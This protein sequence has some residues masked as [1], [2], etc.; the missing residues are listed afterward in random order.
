MEQECCPLDHTVWWNTNVVDP[1]C[2]VLVLSL[3]F[4]ITCTCVYN[5]IGWH[6][7]SLLALLACLR[8]RRGSVH[9]M[10]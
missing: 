5:V 3:C 8:T 2:I 6:V 7:G 1:P 9:V 4:N 10:V